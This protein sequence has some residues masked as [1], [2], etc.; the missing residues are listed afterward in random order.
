MSAYGEHAVAVDMPYQADP[1][2]GEAAAAYLLER[3]GSPSEQ[4]RSVRIRGKSPALL[5]QLLTR[6]ISDRITVSETVT[7]VSSDFHINGVD[8]TVTP[9]LVEATYILAPALPAGTSYWIL[10]TSVFG[11]P[12]QLATF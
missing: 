8:L 4:V 5:T 11:G 3:Y 1:L 2:I 7:G 9:T 6:E 12:E 10:G